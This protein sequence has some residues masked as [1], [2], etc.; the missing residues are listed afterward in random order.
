MIIF[1]RAPVRASGAFCLDPAPEFSEL[2]QKSK[3]SGSVMRIN[4]DFSVVRNPSNFCG[5]FE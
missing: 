3:S 2:L 5:P 4:F 1:S